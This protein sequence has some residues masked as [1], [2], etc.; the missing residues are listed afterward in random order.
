MKQLDL[1]KYFYGAL[2]WDKLFDSEEEMV[3]L[4]KKID[5]KNYMKRHCIWAGHVA[6][7]Q[8]KLKEGKQLDKEDMTLLKSLAGEIYKYHNHL[9]FR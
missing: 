1:S 2:T 3:E 9:N 4:L 8:Q 5:M 6:T 7:L